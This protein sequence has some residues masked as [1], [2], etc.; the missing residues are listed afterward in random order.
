MTPSVEILTERK[1]IETRTFEVR[2]MSGLFELCRSMKQEKFRG[3][4][5][6]IFNDGGINLVST[7]RSEKLPTAT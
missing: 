2:E 5:V 7:E 6:V 4:L 1:V 3:R